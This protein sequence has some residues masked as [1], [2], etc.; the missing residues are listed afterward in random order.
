MFLDI[1]NQEMKR[2]PITFPVVTAC[3]SIDDDKNILDFDF[4]NFISK[5]NRKFGFINIYAGKTSVLSSCCRLRSDI[6]N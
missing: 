5:Q 6:K 2:T 4:L 3:F 1:M